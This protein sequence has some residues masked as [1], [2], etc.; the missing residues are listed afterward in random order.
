[1]LVTTRPTTTHHRDCC[2]DHV[3]LTERELSVLRLVASGRTNAQIATALYISA[4]SV[5]RCIGLLLMRTNADNRAE[6][7]AR[8]Y[9]EGV[10]D[11]TA[12]PPRITDVDCVSLVPEARGSR[13]GGVTP[14]NGVLTSRTG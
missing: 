2:R 6:L 9:V 4:Q 13:H 8:A 1:M 14:I 11:A 3:H 5:G 7:V 10:L 12:W